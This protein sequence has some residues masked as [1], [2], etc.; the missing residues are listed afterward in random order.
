MSLLSPNY[1]EDI[2]SL[3]SKVTKQSIV[4]LII[5]VAALIIATLLSAYYQTGIISLTSIID[6]QKDNV[7]L[8]FL[9]A[10][11]FVFILWGQYIEIGRASCRERV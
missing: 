2:H 5:A 11:P 1:T 9:D 10:T 3:R 4:G 7:V 8:W 6:V